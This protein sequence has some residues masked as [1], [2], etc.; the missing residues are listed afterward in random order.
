MSTRNLLFK[1][2]MTMFAVFA[3]SLSACTSAPT[4]SVKHVVVERILPTATGFF[5][6]ADCDQFQP[7]S[8]RAETQVAAVKPKVDA[9]VPVALSLAAN[10]QI[11]PARVI[12]QDV[13]L[14]TI[15]IFFKN[16]DARLSAQEA[17]R[18]RSFLDGIPARA[19]LSITGY[20]DG[21][22]NHAA[23]LRLA[24]RRA[25]SVK[26][27]VADSAVSRR[28][29][30]SRAAICCPKVPDANEAERGRNRHVVVTVIQ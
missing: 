2:Q 15:K 26:D 13:K 7:T 22:G 25:H 21:T 3:C 23:N 11:V 17:Q 4:T 8:K 9:T 12:A 24:D 16:N 5:V 30:I 20:T 18:L 1:V 29:S 6:C 10:E 28:I 27:F 19:S 14:Q